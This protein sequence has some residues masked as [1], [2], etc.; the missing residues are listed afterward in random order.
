MFYTIAFD[1]GDAIYL[2][3]NHPNKVFHYDGTDR[4]IP[5]NSDQEAQKVEYSGKHHGHKVKNLTIC[6]DIQY[7]HYLS[8][9]EVGSVHDKTMADEYPIELPEGSVLKQDL[10]FLGHAPK[11]VQIEIPFKKP[12][13]GELSFSQKL[14][15]KLLSSTRVVVE[16]SNSGLK[17]LKMLKE[18]IRLYGSAIRDQVMIIAC[19]LHN[20]RVKSPMR[21]Y[22]LRA[23]LM[24]ISA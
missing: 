17:R 10:G 22:A 6:D 23:D 13:N 11:G 7:I 24:K 9:T 2:L 12:R 19:A 21:A 5:R 15:N 14:Y 1:L 20:L 8:P 18:V 16:H 3:L 4:R